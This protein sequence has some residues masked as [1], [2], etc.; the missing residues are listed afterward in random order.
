MKLKSRLL[1][2]S[3]MKA[4]KILDTVQNCA[5]ATEIVQRNAKR[6]S[7]AKLRTWTLLRPSAAAQMKDSI[8]VE[9][10][11]PQDR[12]SLLLSL[13][14]GFVPFWNAVTL[15]ILAVPEMTLSA[16]Y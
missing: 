4:G 11:M 3:L 12:R 1:A 10:N 14:Q 6:A 8:S 2:I 16:L 15:H 9:P 5:A 7:A 13:C